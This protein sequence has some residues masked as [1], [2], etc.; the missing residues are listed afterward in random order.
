LLNSFELPAVQNDTTGT[1]PY[2]HLPIRRSRRPSHTSRQMEVGRRRG[3][4]AHH[5][6][7]V[8]IVQMQSRNGGR[9][10]VLSS[11]LSSSSSSPEPEPEHSSDAPPFFDGSS[12]SRPSATCNGFVSIPN[13]AKPKH[14]MFAKSPC[15]PVVSIEEK[16]SSRLFYSDNPPARLPPSLHPFIIA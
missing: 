15:L 5:E 8:D 9:S 14:A 11:P 4:S 6:H 3:R 1:R 7:R 13:L 12:L 16:P 2:H 10:D